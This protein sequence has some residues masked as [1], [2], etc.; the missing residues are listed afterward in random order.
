MKKYCK[1][2]LQ[3]VNVNDYITCG[4]GKEV[5]PNGY[6]ISQTSPTIAC[7]THLKT[8]L[9]I[10]RSCLRLVS[11]AV[12]SLY[13]GGFGSVLILHTST[14]REKELQED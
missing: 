2:L 12:S 6:L 5:L 8:G 9:I 7:N 1:K 10:Q 11:R 14:V 4:T 3:D 13:S